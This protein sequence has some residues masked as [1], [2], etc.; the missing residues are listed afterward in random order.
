MGLSYS[1]SNAQATRGFTLVELMVTIAI[2]AI[3]LTIGVPSFKAT[4]DKNGLEK[5]KDT[6]ITAINFARSSALQFNRNVL[7]CKR[8]T[9]DPDT[10][11]AAGNWENGWIVYVDKVRNDTLDANDDELLRY[12]EGLGNFSLNED[13][14]LNQIA[15]QSDGRI[16]SKVA[17]SA[18][19]PPAGAT[20]KLCNSDG[21]SSLDIF[22]NVLGRAQYKSGTTPCL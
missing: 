2:L 14:D 13:D 15:F 12:Y 20:F 19:F 11:D 18:D 21:D 17:G 16:K 22:L 4:I 3:A 8:S 9:A 6:F 7:L 5:R 10:C 1:A